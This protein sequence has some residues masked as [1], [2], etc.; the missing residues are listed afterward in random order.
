MTDGEDLEGSAFEAAQ[1]AAKADGIKIYTVGVGTAAGDLIPLPPEQGGGFVK[2]ETGAFVRSRLDEQGLKAIAGAT[3][4]F[5]VPLGTQAEGLELIFQNVLGS[6]AK[7]DLASRQQKIYIERYQWPLAA[8]LAMLLGS[9]AIG[10]RRRSRAPLRA[11][12][13]APPGNLAAGA[14]AW[15]PCT[16][17]RIDPKEPVVEYNTGTAAYRAGQFPQAAQS[18]Q[19]SISHSPSD[20]PKRLAVQEDAYYNL[21]NTLYRSGQKTE[22]TLSSGDS[23]EMERCREGLRNGAANARG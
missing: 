3:G 1:A 22:R 21:G 17:L 12:A 16:R 18:F 4:G 23:A 19:Q 2:D 9:L 15:Q 13:A 10:S 5:Y 14:L 8:S 11:L 7:H 20:D 6:I